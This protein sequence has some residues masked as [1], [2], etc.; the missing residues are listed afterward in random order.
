MIWERMKTS[1]APAHPQI[2]IK[3]DKSVLTVDSEAK[4]SKSVSIAD[5]GTILMKEIKI[6]HEDVVGVKNTPSVRKRV[7]SKYI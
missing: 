4:T 7:S 6:T 2:A 1:K 3:A 5:I